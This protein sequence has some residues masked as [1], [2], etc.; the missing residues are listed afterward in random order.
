MP[1]LMLPFGRMADSAGR[2]NVLGYE[3]QD[4]V[5]AYCRTMGK[6]FNCPQYQRYLFGLPVHTALSA[7]YQ[8]SQRG[9]RE[10]TPYA[11]AEETARLALQLVRDLNPIE[12]DL[13]QN[14]LDPFTGIGQSAYSYAKAG[15]CVTAIENHKIT[16]EIA[17]RNFSHSKYADQIDS[18]VGDGPKE[19]ADAVQT[20]ATYAIVH[21]DPPWGG[22]YDYDTTKPFK[23]Q[24]ISVNILSLV[25]LALEVAYVAVVNLPQNFQSEEI[26]KV[27]KNLGCSAIVQFQYI[28]DYPPCFGQAPV[29]FFR[30]TGSTLAKE[31]YKEIVQLL[32]PDGQ[33][34]ENEE[35]SQ[36]P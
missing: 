8:I 32:T 6:R 9:L 23:L 25:A 35:S 4:S 17:K 31:P 1:D 16:Y 18:K 34:V 22:N 15:C 2:D 19:L 30:T 20:G 33:R 12:I 13:R 5:I 3:D 14:V 28:S 10:T 27:A 11:C 7:G 29:Y 26:R 21:L 24:Y 36:D